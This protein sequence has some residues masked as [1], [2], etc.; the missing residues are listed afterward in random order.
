MIEVR[1][2]ILKSAYP[3]DT[4]FPLLVITDLKPQRTTGVVTMAATVTNQKG[5]TVLEGEHVYLLRL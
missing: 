3:G 2:R 1:A 4:L 5:E